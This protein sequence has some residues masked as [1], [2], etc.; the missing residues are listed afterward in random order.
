M[1]VKPLQLTAKHRQFIS[2]AV[3]SGRF[4]NEQEALNKAFDLLVQEQ[5][6]D[7]E[8]SLEELVQPALDQLDRGLCTTFHTKDEMA[9]HF[10]SLRKKVVHSMLQTS[11]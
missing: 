11:S 10:A 3:K 8:K 5:S 6:R 1:T 2:R 4:R 9:A 7:S